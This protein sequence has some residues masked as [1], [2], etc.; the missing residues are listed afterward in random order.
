MGTREITEWERSLSIDFTTMLNKLT[1]PEAFQ[2]TVSNGDW[3]QKGPHGDHE[4]ITV[5]QT[6]ASAVVLTANRVY[7]LKKPKDFGFFDY[8]SPA[9]RRHFCGQEVRINTRLAPNV[10]LGVAP[11][12]LDTNGQLRFGS[13]LS[14]DDVPSPG[15]ELVGG[16]IVDYAV[17]MVRLSDEAT[18]ASRVQAGR[19]SFPHL[20]E[21][22]RH[23][24]AFHTTTQTDEHI[25]SYGGL[26]VISGNSEENFEQMRP[27]TGLTLETDSYNRITTFVR[28][29]ISERSRLFQS[30]MHEG[31]IRDCHGDLRL[32]H[33]YIL[34]QQGAPDRIDILD[35]IE[36]NDRFRYG[37]VAAEVAFLIMELDAAS[38]AD[39]TK[40]FVDSYITATGD[41][42]IRELLTFYSCYRACV[43]GKVLSFQLNEPEVS[44]T[45]R[46]LARQ[47]ARALFSLAADYAAGPTRPQ[48]IMVGGL[49]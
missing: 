29:F 49:M 19:I 13:T 42:T 28:R 3:F 46:E 17:V 40:V 27:Y 26:D 44:T 30:R 22:A 37:D 43:R 48:V 34:E 31:R 6:H 45:Q 2:D 1:Q 5:I 8:S 21:V 12:L 20:Q 14:P 36:F 35:G 9:L 41:E 10:Y 7:K 4:H 16:T 39:L 32:Q 23:V 18:L 33:V 15:T 11:V 25:A 38:R 47:Q 24:A